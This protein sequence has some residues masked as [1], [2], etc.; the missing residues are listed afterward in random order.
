MTY[1]ETYKEEGRDLW[2][3]N[4]AVWALVD[5]ILSL[6]CPAPSQRVLDIA[7]RHCVL[8]DADILDSE[9]D[10]MKESVSGVLRQLTRKL[11]LP[12]S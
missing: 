12:E 1:P 8:I 7:F 10:E 4:P 3:Q 11:C 9:P 2:R 6:G 5:A